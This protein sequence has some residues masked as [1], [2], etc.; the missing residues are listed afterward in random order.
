MKVIYISLVFH[1]GYKKKSAKNL[2]FMINLFFIF[3]FEEQI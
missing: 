3:Y 2:P 1:C